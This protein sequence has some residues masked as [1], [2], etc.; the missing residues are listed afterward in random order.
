ME[1]ANRMIAFVPCLEEKRDDVVKKLVKIVV[2]ICEDQEISV[3]ESGVRKKKGIDG[4]S[5]ED[6][7]LTVV[8]EVRRWVIKA[9]DRFK[10]KAEKPFK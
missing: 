2:K 7:G 4:E 10:I 6:A 1:C 9:M 3:E 8:Q 5:A